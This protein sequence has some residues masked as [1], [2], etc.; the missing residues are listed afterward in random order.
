M[1]ITIA[2]LRS[3]TKIK[4]AIKAANEMGLAYNREIIGINFSTLD[5]YDLDLKITF[6]SQ[7]MFQKY[8]KGAKK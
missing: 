3:I 4:E 2:K 5:L 8:Q 1:P 6:N 7:S